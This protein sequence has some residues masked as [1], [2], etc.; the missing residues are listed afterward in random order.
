MICPPCQLCHSKTIPS[1]RQGAYQ[2]WECTCC[3]TSQVLPQPTEDELRRFYEHFHADDGV[4]ATV[5]SRMRA[6]F[7]SKARLVRSLVGATATR[8]LDVGCGKGYFL[9]AAKEQNFDVVGLDISQSGINHAVVTLEL[10]ARV[11]S[12]GAEVPLDWIGA[13]DVVTLWATLEHV[14]D[15]P[16]IL[17]GINRCLRPGGWLILDTGLGGAPLHSLLPGYSQWFDAPEHLWV[18]TAVSLKH[19]LTQAGF[20]TRSIDYNFERNLARRL[21]RATRNATISIIGYSIFRPLLGNAGFQF[22]R[23]NAKWPL[24]QLISICAQKP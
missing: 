18:F 19:L 15:P 14:A 20:E 4:Y 10:D 7:P 9:N 13:F 2:Y 21:A 22:L 3:G 8:L 17:R 16:S 12:I 23:S 11:G 1:V 6:D 5:D 24:G